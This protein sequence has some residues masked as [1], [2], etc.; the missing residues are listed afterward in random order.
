MK[1]DLDGMTAV[2]YSR[3]STDD[4]DQTTESQIREMKRWCEDKGVKVI[5]I[6]S[7]QI[8]GKDLERPEYDRM[9]GRIMRGGSHILLCWSESRLTRNTTNLK[10]IESQI[11]PYGTRIRFVTNNV[12]PETAGDVISYIGVWQAQEERAKLSM[13]TKNGMLNRK[14]QGI[15][16]GRPLA[17]VF[18][19]R[20][21]ENKARI[22]LD[23]K[24]KIKIVSLDTV[25]QNAQL[26]Y[27]VEKTSKII[28]VSATSLKEALEQEDKLKEYRE[29]FKKIK[30]GHF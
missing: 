7:E 23:G 16:C 24:Q 5:W 14:L 2:L 22:K 9:M 20:V 11:A 13:N 26:G 6:Y 27:S 25:M 12:E 21:E 15:H 4:K 10:D 28:G 8:S 17:I 29:I 19:H 1:S 3:V 18:S 30:Y